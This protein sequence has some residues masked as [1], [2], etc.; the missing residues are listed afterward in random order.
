MALTEVLAVLTWSCLCRM[1]QRHVSKE[2]IDGGSVHVWLD[3]TSTLPRFRLWIPS[4]LT[5]VDVWPSRGGAGIWVYL[6][7]FYSFVCRTVF[8]GWA[9]FSLPDR[10]IALM[11]QKKIH[12]AFQVIKWLGYENIINKD[13]LWEDL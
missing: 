7:L 9:C 2:V 11:L 12:D 1:M 10:Q 8:P 6:V 5:D 4:K 13:A 3:L